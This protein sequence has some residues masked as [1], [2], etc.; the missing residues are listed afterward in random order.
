MGEFF[1]FNFYFN[2]LAMAMSGTLEN[3]R[4]FNNF[5]FSL[6]IRHRTILYCE[7]RTLFEGKK[8]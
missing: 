8:Y 4:I 1:F 7:L 2:V 6:G 5:C 3:K